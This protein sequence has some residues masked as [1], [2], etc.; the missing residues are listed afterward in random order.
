MEAGY[1]REELRWV[2]NSFCVVEICR[3]SP[4]KDKT[5]WLPY[6]SVWGKSGR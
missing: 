4:Q 6:A 3:E 2:G 5:G 1:R